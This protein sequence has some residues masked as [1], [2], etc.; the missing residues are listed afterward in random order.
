[1]KLKQKSL[2]LSVLNHIKKV[3]LHNKISLIT[4]SQQNTMTHDKS[5][6]TDWWPKMKLTPLLQNALY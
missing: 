4:S 2:V 6:I 3:N 5:N 1:M